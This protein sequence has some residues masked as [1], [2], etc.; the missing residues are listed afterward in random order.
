MSKIFKISIF[1]DTRGCEYRIER[2]EIK[3]DTEKQITTMS[4]NRINKNMFVVH[5]EQIRQS[6]N[7][8]RFTC[9]CYEKDEE[10]TKELLLKRIVTEYDKMKSEFETLGNYITKA[11]N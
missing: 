6:H 3:K 2:F 4:G 8:I 5:T 10:K 7:Y 11:C 9:Y 1:A